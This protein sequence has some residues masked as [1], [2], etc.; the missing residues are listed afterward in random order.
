[1]ACSVLAVIEIV[2]D[3]QRSLILAV[4]CLDSQ[5][6][7]LLQ[8]IC[9]LAR[10]QS[11][12]TYTM[13]HWLVNPVQETRTLSLYNIIYCQSAELQQGR[14]S[15]ALFSGVKDKYYFTMSCERFILHFRDFSAWYN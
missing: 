4:S 9:F 1:M 14:S 15:R 11:R 2:T 13:M 5:L 7:A 3:V 10:P 12:F 8:S 6:R